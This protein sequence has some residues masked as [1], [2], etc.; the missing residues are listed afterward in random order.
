M[1]SFRSAWAL[2][3]A[4][5][6]T[7][8][9]TGCPSGGGDS[10][11]QGGPGAQSETSGKLSDAHPVPLTPPEP[12]KIKMAFVPSNEADTIIEGTKKLDSLLSA[13][14][15][16]PVES[17][18]L[19]HYV[20]AVEALGTGDCLVGWLPP[21]AYIY[22]NQR[23]QARVALKAVRKGTPYY[24]GQLIV[25]SDSPIQTLADCR[26]KRFAWVD[27]T[28]TSGYLYPRAMLKAAGIDPDK[29]LGDSVA[30][31]SHDSVVIS[32]LQG[33]VDVGACY[34]DARERAKEINPKVMEET[35]V[36]AKTDPIPGDAVV[37]SGP[38]YLSDEWAKKLTGA[39]VE[40]MHS[41]E[42][43][44]IIFDIYEIEDLLPA[45][46]SDYDVVRKMA[47]ELDLDVEAQ[48]GKGK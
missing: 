13:K 19:P 24:Y 27:P 22:A 34:V 39:L 47:A 9:F 38:T 12:V 44:K 14:L 18:V 42:G 15:G 5:V 36:I 41:G 21:L 45:S 43:K 6:F 31:G 11:G 35:R 30:T 7:L 23:H 40:V 20:A 28:S 16:I 46:D 8:L 10:D 1:A 32:V 2:F 3:A 48:L 4:V 29:D 17:I 26:G 33:S 25:R 37:L